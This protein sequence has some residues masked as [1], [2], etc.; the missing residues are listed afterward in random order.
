MVGTTV[1]EY[2][3]IAS[4]YRHIFPKPSA[5]PIRAAVATSG[6]ATITKG[7]IRKPTKEPIKETTKKATKK[8][9]TTSSPTL[10]QCHVLSTYAND[11]LVHLAQRRTTET[12]VV[13]D[14]DAQAEFDEFWMWVMDAKSNGE[15]RE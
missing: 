9:T 15:A 5:E 3:A 7:P 13:T 11:R 14:E 12:P 6:P 2:R 8:A 1:S 4:R 10:W